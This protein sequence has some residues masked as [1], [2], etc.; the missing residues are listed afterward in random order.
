MATNTAA[1]TL[2]VWDAVLVLLQASFAVQVLI[3]EYDPLQFGVEATSLKVN[4]AALQL[5][6]AIACSNTGVEL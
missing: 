1:R 3:I 5:S 6:V 4:I 2:I